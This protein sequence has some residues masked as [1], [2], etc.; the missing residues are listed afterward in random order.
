MGVVVGPPQVGVP[1]PA[2][3]APAGSSTAA[4]AAA[5][6]AVVLRDLS[7]AFV[8]S[9]SLPPGTRGRIRREPM[10][11]GLTQRHAKP[12]STIRFHE[13]DAPSTVDCAI[14]QVLSRRAGSR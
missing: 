9:K 4:A 11:A 5:A 12:N 7:I 1:P 3:A 10:D 2:I 6:N 8:P 14:D 13:Q